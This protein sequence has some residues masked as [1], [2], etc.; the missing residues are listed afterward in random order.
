MFGAKVGNSN[1]V[2]FPL[3][4][5]PFFIKQPCSTRR[6]KAF[7]YTVKRHPAPIIVIARHTIHWNF[8]PRENL[9]RLGQKLPFLHDVA[10]KADKIR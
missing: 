2:D 1:E 5:R 3:S 4:Y 8:D 10:R 6:C 7:D 9:K